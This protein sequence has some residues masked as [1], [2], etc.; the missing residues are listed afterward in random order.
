MG[1]GGAWSELCQLGQLGL[2]KRTTLAH[3]APTRAAYKLRVLCET[4]FVGLDFLLTSLE[5]VAQKQP[6]IRAESDEE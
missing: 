2:T 6:K 3:T 4:E 5:H 1:E